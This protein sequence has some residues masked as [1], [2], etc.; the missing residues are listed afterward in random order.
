M[1]QFAMSPPS[2]NVVAVKIHKV[3]VIQMELRAVATPVFVVSMLRLKRRW[4]KVLH[5]KLHAPYN[6]ILVPLIRFPVL[7]NN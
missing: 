7:G 6:M 4:Y 5:N 2:K 3:C 1:V